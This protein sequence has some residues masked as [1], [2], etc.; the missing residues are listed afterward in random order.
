M[1]ISARRNTIPILASLEAALS[2]VTIRNTLIAVAL[3]I[4]TGFWFSYTPDDAFIS[5]RF[6]RNIALGRGPVFNVGQPV[7]GYTSPLWVFALGGM[8]RL[9]LPIEA[10]ATAIP[11]L[12]AGL[13]VALLPATSRRLGLKLYGLDA[14]L[15]ATNASFVLWSGEAME[16]V[17]FAA[18]LVLA[19]YLGLARRTQWIAA[20]AGAALALLRPEGLLFVAIGLAVAF[21]T[22]LRREPGSV[23]RWVLLAALAVI[24]V[25]LHLAWRLSY[26]G[27][28]LPNTYYVKVGWT[29][30]MVE[31]GARY[32][33]DAA[34]QYILPITIP[35]ILGLA[36]FATR[37]RLFVL[38]S[39]LAY[40]GYVTMVGGDWMPGHRFV[41]LVMPFLA[42]GAALGLQSIG[43]FVSERWRS[44]AQPVSVYAGVIVLLA[45]N[46]YP[47]TTTDM[48]IVGIGDAKVIAQWLDE[49]C[50]QDRS[51]AVFAAGA[52]PWYSPDRPIVDMFGLMDKELAH[53]DWPTMGTGSWAGHE[54]F[55]API[56]LAKNPDIF[57]FQGELASYKITDAD[58]WTNEPL[59]HLIRQFTDE[60]S[61]WAE[62]S[63]QSAPIGNKYF[64]FVVRN[65]YPCR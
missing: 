43:R 63:T 56:T 64:N 19:T 51:I 33:A 55:S 21:L 49:H 44:L 9:G 37:R 10:T 4:A 7:E 18:M 11:I 60:E 48:Q 27:Y 52:L 17:V 50:P 6:S 54:K 57:I 2:D 38:L 8:T 42:M 59:G 53:T 32:L 58:Q 34:W 13:A 47:V 25:A 24:P 62:H 26:Y 36:A 15:L 20:L 28:P 23:R 41:V 39:A 1:E 14:L 40:L 45:A 30:A 35:A 3:V 65:P 29:V 22:V 46:L 12:A 16:M 31:R 61:F 5:F